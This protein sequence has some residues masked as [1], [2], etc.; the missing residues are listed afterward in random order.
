MSFLRPLLWVHAVS[1]VA[2]VGSAAPDAIEFNR[3]V[4]P[5]LS[6]N[7]FHCHGQDTGT[8]KGGL[9]LDVRDDA[10][11][12]GKS[13]VP[14][15]VPGNPEESELLLRAMSPHDDEQMPP[16]DSNKARLSATDLAKLKAWIAG[17]AEY[18]DHWA[19]IP[20]RQ[21]PIPNGSSAA[22]ATRSPRAGGPTQTNLTNQAGNAIDQF[23]SARLQREGLSLSP[24][25]DS[26][27]L[28]RRLYLDVTGLPPSPADVAAFKREGFEATLEKLLQSEAYGEKWARLWL[29]AAR[30]SDSN[31]Y[32]KDL[33][34][35][36]W[37]WRDWVIRSINRDQPYNQFIVEQIAGDLLPNATQDQIV[38]TGF[39]RNSM[40]N[41]E[42]AIVTEQFRTE[43]IFDRMDC[44]GKAVLGL[45][46]S[47]A[48][49]H[50]HK[51]DPIEHDEY[52]G[53]FAFINDTYEA[54]SWVYT[55]DQQQQVADVERAIAILEERVRA[56]QPDWRQ[57]IAAWETSVREKQIAWTPLT[58]T[59]MGSNSGLNHPT[60]NADASIFVLGHPSTRGT[61]YVIATPELRGATGLRL[62]ALTHRDLPFN[63]PGRSKYG[64]WALS[65]L[66]VTVQTPGTSEWVPV[67]LKNATTDFAE[68]AAKLEEDWDADFDKE[69]KRTR[70]PVEFLIDGNKDTGWRADRGPGQRNQESVAVVQFECPLEYPVGTK[71]RVM[72]AM[73]HGGSDNGRHNTILG[74]LRLSLTGAPDPKALAIDHAAILALS[75]PPGQR[76][77]AEQQAIFTAWRQSLPEASSLTGEFEAVWKTYPKAPTSVLHLAQRAPHETRETRLLDRGGWDQPKHVVAPGTPAALHPFPADR[78][79]NRLGLAEWLVDRRSPL[80]ARVAVN[81][82]WQAVFGQGLAETPEDFGTRAPIPV[83]LDLLDWLA[84]DFMDHGWSQKRLLRTLLSSAVYRQSSRPTPELLERDPRNVLLARGPRFRLEAEVLRD[85]ALKVAGLLTEQVG[86]P[87]IFPPVPASVLEYNYTKPTYWIPATGAERYRRALYVFRKRSMPDPVLNVFDAPNGDLACVRR[88]R[89]NTPLAA[90]TSLNEPIFVEAAQALALRIL[91]EGGSTDAERADFA[92]RL[93]TSRPIKPSEHE[94]I[95]TL[96]RDTRARLAEGW[97]NAR[98]LATG[99][100]S[101]LPALPPGTTPQDAAAWTVVARVLLNLDETLNKS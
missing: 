60:Q 19:F 62:E 88:A 76:S 2:A 15:L 55:K 92:Y 86:G 29:D 96:L 81:R 75:V 28:C 72:M 36:Q 7:C 22:G 34:R 59:E 33:P 84:V 58:A 64:T 95:A 74:R 10:L 17:G 26:E 70:G 69:K 31:G 3:D 11:K 13:G 101:R 12:G 41:E 53:L 35:E 9:R 68:S 16:A 57:D 61:I 46:L 27:T 85:T 50:T 80:T 4:R 79:R 77:P 71:F 6:D 82:V 21:V 87:S 65:E 45:T 56:Q 78:P 99:D 89:S 40:T 98:E 18:Q 23:V 38:A 63:G 30:Y 37:A 47:C 1:F 100:A 94:P 43:E 73:D 44:V 97:L 52:F 90:L 25:A 20:P 24:E 66:T 8:R 93:C 54:Q 83:Y 42:G 49:C 51:F 67:R 91:R 32:E 5:I 14:A 48:Q 39:L